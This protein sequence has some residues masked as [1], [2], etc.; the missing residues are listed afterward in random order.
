MFSEAEYLLHNMYFDMTGKKDK[1]EPALDYL[2]LKDYN[3]DMD[4]NEW[5]LNKKS[6]IVDT[7]TYITDIRQIPVGKLYEINIRF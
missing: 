1:I 5:R 2:L 3:G 6:V 7:E 4:I